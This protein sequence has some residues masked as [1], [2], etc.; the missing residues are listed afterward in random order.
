MPAAT[1]RDCVQRRIGLQRPSGQ[2]TAR[3][4][5]GLV[6]GAD[7]LILPIIH[8]ATAKLEL[9]YPKAR[10]SSRCGHREL[11]NRMKL[12]NW[13]DLRFGRARLQSCRMRGPFFALA[14]AAEGG[15]C[16]FYPV[17]RGLKPRILGQFHGT[18]KVVPF[19]NSFLVRWKCAC[20]CPDIG[21]R[22]PCTRFTGPQGLWFRSHASVLSVGR[23]PSRPRWIFL[24][25]CPP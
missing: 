23:A 15:S 7:S 11:G 14:L 2:S 10:H 18:T 21:K 25:R 8:A 13:K 3:P 17:P 4:V 9:V 20:D 22:R 5:Q 16:R 24:P 6:W 19:Q 1:E 12:V